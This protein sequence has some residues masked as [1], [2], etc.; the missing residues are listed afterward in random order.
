MHTYQCPRIQVDVALLTLLIIFRLTCLITSIYGWYSSSGLWFQWQSKHG[1]VQGS[2]VFDT[3][4][5]RTP[6]KVAP[7]NSG[8]VPGYP[9]VRVTE[10]EVLKLQPG[11][12]STGRA[13]DFNSPPRKVLIKKKSKVI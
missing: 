7:G 11:R 12:A 10:K 1:N 3:E 9:D 4:F 13:Q 8:K 5:L 2:D 6:E